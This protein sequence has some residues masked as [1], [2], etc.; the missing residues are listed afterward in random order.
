M[1]R[2]KKV[3]ILTRLAATPDEPTVREAISELRALRRR[4]ALLESAKRLYR[5]Q[6]A[7]D[8]ECAVSKECFT[9][10]SSDDIK[11]K[12]V[13]EHDLFIADGRVFAAVDTD[14]H[15]YFMDAITGSLYNFG[16]CLTSP[17]GRTGF[18]RDQAKA[19]AMLMAWKPKGDVDGDGDD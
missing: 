8:A 7:A 19:S 9:A 11:R 6:K 2:L 15:M 4:V 13:Q 12:W 17:R 18:V 16:E 10:V 1:S 14:T 5:I 3:D